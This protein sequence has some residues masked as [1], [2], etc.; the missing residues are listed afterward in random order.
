MPL[1]IGLIGAT[2][3]A[4]K[5]VIV[6]SRQH[7]DVTVRAVAASDPT[8]AKE[9]AA[10]NEIAHVHDDYAALVDDPAINVVYVSLHNS[11]HAK[12][13]ANAA[14]AGK[15]VI[16]EKPLCL[17]TSELAAIAAAAESTGV[18]VI[19]AVPTAGHEWPEAVREFGP[20]RSARTEIRFSAPK[21]D[22][23]RA[24]PE[25]GGG[26]FLDSASYWLEAMQ[27]VIG[28]DGEVSGSSAFDGPNG[29]D[30]AFDAS[31]TLPDGVESSLHCEVGD[32]HVAEHEF[33]FEHASVRLRNFLRPT[34][35]ALPLNLA[36]RNSDG[37]KSIRSFPAVSYYDRQLSRIKETIAS[38]R[39]ELAAAAERVTVMAAIHRRAREAV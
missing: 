31:L 11:A 23:Y 3:I 22:G 1:D 19:E 32:T 20:P 8:R 34:V 24:R 6:P 14:R 28:L 35:G 12:W 30:R 17:D 4:E 27:A 33:T 5:A 13:A 18:R 16:V 25:L 26:I 38:G 9:F 21:P 7:D 29:V 37:T 10:R 2:A 36:I 15:H 39:D